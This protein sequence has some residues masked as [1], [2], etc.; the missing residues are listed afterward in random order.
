MGFL[1]RPIDEGDDD[2]DE[3]IDIAD[4]SDEMDEHPAEPISLIGG[5][6]RDTPERT[7][8]D[9]ATLSKMRQTLALYA[10]HSAALGVSDS[11]NI[12]NPHA[13]G[14]IS[15]AVPLDACAAFDFNGAGVGPEWE[16][17]VHS[18]GGFAVQVIEP[19]KECRVSFY[20]P[21]SYG[22]DEQAERLQKCNE[23]HDRFVA[24]A[25]EWR[26]IGFE[27]DVLRE[28]DEKHPLLYI[29]RPLSEQ[30]AS[31]EADTALGMIVQ[32]DP[33]DAKPCNYIPLGME[34]TRDAEAMMAGAIS[35]NDLER[36]AVLRRRAGPD[37][38][39]FGAML[40]PE[41]RGVQSG[42]RF[43]VERLLPANGSV[44][45]LGDSGI[46]KST[47]AHLLLHTMALPVTDDEPRHKCLDALEVTPL[48]ENEVVALVSA[49]DDL[50]TLFERGD[51]FDPEHRTEGRIIPLDARGMTFDEV[52][53][54]LRAA[55]NLKVFVVDPLGSFIEGDEND[56]GA[57]NKLL[58]RIDALA[59]DKDAL[60][61]V[62]H[63]TK[64]SKHRV[65]SLTG[66]LDNIR[67][68]SALKAHMRMVLCMFLRPDGRTVFGVAKHN[69][70]PS[71]NVPAPTDAFILERQPD[72][73][74]YALVGTTSAKP[75]AVQ[76]APEGAGDAVATDPEA[77]NAGP[78][79]E[80][81]TALLGAGEVIAKTGTND[82]YSRRA[83]HPALSGLSRARLRNI[84]SRLEADGK[85]VISK[86]RLKMPE[87]EA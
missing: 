61:I 87:G 17:H 21:E 6:P 45:L 66:V 72:S 74:G 48:G 34:F 36:M 43:R 20:D 24:L 9:D 78:V 25:T 16:I 68:S 22:I 23:A 28:P 2:L 32:S 67:G 1:G 53:Q 7:R 8:P 73:L 26:Q 84:T 5:A 40:R 70:P 18:F 57:V 82:L 51:A 41:L 42:V 63:H 10:A 83:A 27:A 14:D 4:A 60:A 39:I 64:K 55:P 81:I 77:M 33:D 30:A 31:D 76:N 44:M 47:L 3:G 12:L 79:L 56:A 29:V 65:S 46:G 52:D 35:L 15:L 13:E 50:A 86:G 49:E 62:I 38:A 58:G 75:K 59:R 71:C 54:R 19:P 85:I 37:V 80:V 69:Y 11:V